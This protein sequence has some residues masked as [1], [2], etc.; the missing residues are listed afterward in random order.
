[1]STRNRIAR[2][3]QRSGKAT[4]EVY[5]IQLAAVGPISEKSDSVTFLVGSTL[6]SKSKKRDSVTFLL[7]STF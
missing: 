3:S 6:W 2:V 5:H 1:M 4:E 7:S